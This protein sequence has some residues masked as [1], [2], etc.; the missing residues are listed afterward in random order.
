[1]KILAESPYVRINVPGRPIPKGRPR[2]GRGGRTFTPPRTAK[3]EKLIRDEAMVQMFGKDVLKGP[4]EMYIDFY[5]PLNKSFSKKK[6]GEMMG[7]GRTMLGDPAPIPCMARVDVD[8]C[9]KC[10]AD[11]LNGVVYED[12]YQIVVIHSEKHWTWPNNGRTE[13]EVYPR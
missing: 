7:D 13:I 2:L 10:V 9:M 3:H 4:V 12:D 1:M 11:A 8:N 6:Q 5:F